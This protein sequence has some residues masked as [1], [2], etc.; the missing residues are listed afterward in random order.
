MW[1]AQSVHILSFRPVV[2]FSPS[3]RE[4][5]SETGNDGQFL[6]DARCAAAANGSAD[7]TDKK[8]KG[9]PDQGRSRNP[10]QGAQVNST[11]PTLH[12]WN[13]VQALL[14]LFKSPKAQVGRFPGSRN[15]THARHFKFLCGRTSAVSSPILNLPALQTARLRC[16]RR[17]TAISHKFTHP[18][19]KVQALVP[20]C[21]G[22]AKSY[23]RDICHS[24][25]AVQRQIAGGCNHFVSNEFR[26]EQGSGLSRGNGMMTTNGSFIPTGKTVPASNP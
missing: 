22:A 4:G 12:F 16:C 9:A 26:S 7:Q 8:T 21:S 24:C 17:C 3:T 5:T 19:R 14:H 1:R 6:Q 15:L 10:D 20:L 13:A 11:R 23:A 2:P 18:S 25:A